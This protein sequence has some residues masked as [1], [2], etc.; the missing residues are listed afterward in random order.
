M[1]VVLPYAHKHLSEC[2]LPRHTRHSTRPPMHSQACSI[3][4]LHWCT[5]AVVT[6]RVHADAKR[7]SELEPE[8]KVAAATA[9]RLETAVAQEQEKM[10]EE[11]LGSAHAHVLHA[12]GSAAW[13]RC[14]VAHPPRTDSDGPKRW[15]CTAVGIVVTARFD[16]LCRQAERSGQ[17]HPRQIRHEHKRLRMRQRSQHWL[18]LDRNEKEVERL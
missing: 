14:S 12:A 17:H 7:A 6:L 18:V 1:S 10:K 15:Q 5:Q 4:P 16:L 3:L 11:M 9:K 2:C 8:N 13:G